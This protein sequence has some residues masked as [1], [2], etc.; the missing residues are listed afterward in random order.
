MVITPTLRG[1]FGITIDAQSKTI[2]VNPH[3]PANWDHAEIK[4]LPIGDQTVDLHFVRDKGAVVVSLGGTGRGVTLVPQNRTASPKPEARGPKAKTRT[5]GSNSLIPDQPVQIAPVF[6]PPLPG[7]RAQ[8]PRIVNEEYSGRA[9]TL[10]IEGLRRQRGALSPCPLRA[11]FDG[12]W[13]EAPRYRRRSACFSPGRD[14][15]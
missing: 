4:N 11:C 3:L 9:L 7:G 5:A 14:T 2:T 15:R 8:F 12:D 6:Q 13:S 10:M 1:L